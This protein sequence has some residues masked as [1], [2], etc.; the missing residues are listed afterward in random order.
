MALDLG[1][2]QHWWSD[3]LSGGTEHHFAGTSSE[4]APSPFPGAASVPSGA[5]PET[6]AE[7]AGNAAAGA[8]PAGG[9]AVRRSARNHQRAARSRSRYEAQIHTTSRRQTAARPQRRRRAAA[10]PTARRRPSEAARQV[11]AGHKGRPRKG[12]GFPW[13]LAKNRMVELKALCDARELTIG[14]SIM[15]P[16]LGLRFFRINIAWSSPL[17]NAY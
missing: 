11:R 14:V 10:G 13:K 7:P 1:D 2:R 6:A 15:A 5:A 3:I 16:L 12:Q 4:R 9:A 17:K 8:T